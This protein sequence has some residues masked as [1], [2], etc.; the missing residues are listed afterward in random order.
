MN[1]T[2]GMRHSTEYKT[3][4]SIIGRCTNKRNPSY[5]RYGGKGVTICAEWRRDFAAFFAEVGPRP[6]GKTI[7][8]I[9]NAKGYEPGNCRWATP[10]EQSRN[11]N[12]C[13]LNE[14]S[15][16]SIRERLANGE[17][18]TEIAKSIGVSLAVVHSVKRGRT[19]KTEPA[20][21]SPISATERDYRTEFDAGQ[22][23]EA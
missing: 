17:T 23:G 3:W 10:T 18:Q 20:F 8:R 2:H 14:Q 6:E 22:D 9:D 11:R 7:D 4:C 13:V 15:A 5:P 12:H 21:T 19:W 1:R 16:A